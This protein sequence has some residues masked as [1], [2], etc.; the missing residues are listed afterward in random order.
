MKFFNLKHT[1]SVK[2]VAILLLLFYHLFS[3]PYEVL[4]ME[5]N[6]SPFPQSMFLTFAQFGNVCVA[7]FVFMTAFG[8]SRGLFNQQDF[9]THQAYAQANHRFFKV[10]TDFFIVFLSANLLWWKKIDYASIYGIGKQGI[11]N[12]LLNATGLHTFFEGPTLNVTWW[13]MK[14]AY[15]LIFLVPMIAIL[16]KHI[17]YPV[18]IISLITPF[19]I[20]ISCDM[21]RYLFTVTLGVCTAYGNWPEKIMNSKIPLFLQWPSGIAAF[22]FFVVF[23][24]NEFIHANYLFIVDGLIALFLLYFSG[25]L[26][27]RIPI[28][29]C[30][31]Q[32]I[33]KHSMNIFLVHT[34]FYSIFWR[35]YIYHFKYAGV[36][37]LVLLSCSLLYSVLLEFVKKYLFA[38]IQKLKKSDSVTQRIL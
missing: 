29:N 2:G 33:G 17:G 32:F 35:K 20:P 4:A 23:R 28:L 21:D 15:V 14:I 25:I 7:V 12:F 26:L 10:M 8:I 19:V 22:V 18:L 3:N 34:F 5:V 9:T 1:Y 30:I 36:T 6:Y 16:T 24:Q 31:L 38:S 11:L 13:Y 27:D 37:F